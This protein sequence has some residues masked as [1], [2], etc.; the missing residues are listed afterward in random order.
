MNGI[1]IMLISL[2]VLFLAYVL[3]GRW[4][5]KKWG[6]DPSRKT[7][8]YE[9]R[10]GVDY[11]PAPRSVVFGHQFASIA[12][13]GPIKGLLFRRLFLVG[14]LCFCGCLSVVC[15]S[16]LYRT[17][18]LCTLLSETRAEVSDT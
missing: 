16:V 6:I 12:G 4:I 14:C 7:P 9:Q 18:F 5:A 3:Y 8:A 13:A 17:L 1:T 11:E 15:S 10:D 2:A